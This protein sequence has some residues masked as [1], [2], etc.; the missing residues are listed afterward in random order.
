MI[1]V[2]IHGVNGADT[3]DA[4]TE[5]LDTITKALP[6]EGTTSFLA[7]TITQ[8]AKAIE[9]AMKNAG[10]YVDEKQKP[11]HAE[12]LGIHLEGPFLNSERAGAQPLHAMQRPD[13]RVF[14][15]WNKLAKD[16]IKLVTLA[17]EKEGG[18]GA[19]SLFD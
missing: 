12:V 16:K 18:H 4:T 14:E 5:A 19:Y 6:A 11:G 1:D 10:E 3:M 7:T 15:A 17:P 8:E 2:H 13:I 9:R